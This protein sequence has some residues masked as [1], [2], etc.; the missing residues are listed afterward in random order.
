MVCNHFEFIKTVLFVDYCMQSE[1]YGTAPVSLPALT[2]Y[3]KLGFMPNSDG[4]SAIK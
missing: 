3:R 1:Q 2:A 4:K